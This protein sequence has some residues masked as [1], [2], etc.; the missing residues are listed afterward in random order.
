MGKIHR[1]PRFTTHWL[2]KC[3]SCRKAEKAAKKGAF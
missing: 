1:W 3:S 2:G